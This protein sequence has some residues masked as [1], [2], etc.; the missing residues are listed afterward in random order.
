MADSAAFVSS[1]YDAFARG[2]VPTVLAALDEKVEW[3]EAEHFP[4][5]AGMPF[6]GPQAVVDGVFMR[7]PQDYDGFRI[8]VGRIVGCGDTVLVEGRYRGTVR[9]SGRPLDVQMAH[10]CD[11]R[12]GK[13]VRFQQYVDTWEVA[14]ATGIVP[15][16]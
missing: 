5:W 7:I 6:V 13:V 3:N 9:G 12:N 8:E 14:Q 4:Y 1:L 16:S 10:I 15:A 2:D 11:V